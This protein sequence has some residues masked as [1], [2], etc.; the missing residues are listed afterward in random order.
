MSSGGGSSVH[1]GGSG[2]GFGFDL[3]FGDDGWVLLALIAVQSTAFAV[4]SP[5]RQAI[6]PRLVGPDELAAANTLNFTVFTAASV[7]GP[8]AAG[9]VLLHAS[10]AAAYAVDALAFTAG[11][12]ENRGDVRDAIVARLAFLQ[13]FDVAVVP[14][15]EEL[16]IARAVRSLGYDS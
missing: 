3:D 12:G 4:S 9:L 8:L 6:I 5:A 13:P 1:A 15:H 14:A 16:T 2:S 11:L 7:A 10:V